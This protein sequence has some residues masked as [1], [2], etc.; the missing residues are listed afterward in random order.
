MHGWVSAYGFKQE[1]NYKGSDGN[2]KLPAM[3]VDDKK[4]TA[5][6][7]AGELMAIPIAMAMQWYDAGASPDGS[8]PGLHLKPLDA[9]IGR[10]PAPYCPGGRH[11]RRIR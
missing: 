1:Y 5:T 4:S 9:A 3:V 8:H 6:K 11:G 10:V 2:E 7:N